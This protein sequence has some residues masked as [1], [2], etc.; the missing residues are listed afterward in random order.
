MARRRFS[1]RDIDEILAYW[2]QI[3]SIQ[4]TAT[5]LGVHRDTVRKY[6]QLAREKGYLPGTPPPPEGWAAFVRET[7]PQ[8]VGRTNPSEALQRIAGS[9][10]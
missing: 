9:G 6:V 4:G 8:L 5:S 7:I 1:V 3:D 10:R 2:H